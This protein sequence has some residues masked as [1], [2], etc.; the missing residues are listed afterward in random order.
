MITALT[1]L[2]GAAI[3]VL[4][5]FLVDETRERRS[6]KNALEHLQAHLG[7]LVQAIQAAV[8]THR[9]AAPELSAQVD[10]LLHLYAARG[11]SDAAR[12]TVTRT[13]ILDFYPQLRAFR[14]NLELARSINAPKEHQKPASLLE[15]SELSAVKLSNQFPMAEALFESVATRAAGG[16]SGAFAQL[17]SVAAQY[18]TVA[19]ANT[20]RGSE[21]YNGIYTHVSSTVTAIHES[22]P[23]QACNR[24][25]GHADSLL[26]QLKHGA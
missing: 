21:G 20:P 16:D 2:A 6:H 25:L 7:S 3:G 1:A 12:S 11:L 8:N 14:D 9:W 13:A 23:L 15:F 24:L 10:H 18:L 19:R 22:F 5:K 26:T 4:L 17:D